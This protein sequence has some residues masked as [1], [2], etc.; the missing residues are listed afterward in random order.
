MD[1]DLPLQLVFL[2]QQSTIWKRRNRYGWINKGLSSFDPGNN[3]YIHLRLK[4]GLA[5]VAIFMQLN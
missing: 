2:P 5:L 1:D 4:G 3:I